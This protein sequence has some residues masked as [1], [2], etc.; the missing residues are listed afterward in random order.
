[1]CSL[2]MQTATTNCLVYNRLRQRSDR[3]VPILITQS[4]LITYEEDILFLVYR[5]Q[6]WCYHLDRLGESRQLLYRSFDSVSFW[7]HNMRCIGCYTHCIEREIDELLFEVMLPSRSLIKCQK[8]VS[9]SCCI[10]SESFQAK[11]GS[12]ACFNHMNNTSS[13]CSGREYCP[14]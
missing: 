8:K 9:R 4:K 6:L 14:P 12:G 7:C 11:G 1:M 5:V 2:F 10:M 13:L 3:A